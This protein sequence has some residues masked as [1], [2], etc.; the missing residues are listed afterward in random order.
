LRD[1]LAEA[2]K[3]AKAILKIHQA[4]DGVDGRHVRAM[5]ELQKKGS[6]TFDYATTS[7]SKLSKWA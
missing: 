2:L 4:L 1:S 6:I 5:L 3:L 7:V